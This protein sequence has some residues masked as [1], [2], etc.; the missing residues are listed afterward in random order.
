MVEVKILSSTKDLTALESLKVRD[1]TDAVRLDDLNPGEE[2]VVSW[3]YMVEMHVYNEKS[4]NEKEYDKAVYVD[5]DGAKYVTGSQTFRDKIH[6]LANQ[7]E[8]LR[9]AGIEEKD[10]RLKIFKKPSTNYKDKHFITAT[11]A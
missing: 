11:I 4:K 5:G 8:E 2:L 9:A 6:E 10:L 7:I 3:G 1:Y